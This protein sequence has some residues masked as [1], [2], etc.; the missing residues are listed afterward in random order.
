MQDEKI[1]VDIGSKA[2]LSSSIV[3]RE[4]EDNWGLL[5][6][7]DTGATFGLNPVSL[8]ICRQMDGQKTI[9]DIL[10]LINEKCI[11]VPDEVEEHVEVFIQKLVEKNYVEIF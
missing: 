7:P 11:D 4:E 6:D 1:R 3:I 8:I 5:Y 9:T 10:E 2:A